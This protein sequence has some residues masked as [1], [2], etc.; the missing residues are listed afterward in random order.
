MLLSRYSINSKLVL[1]S[2]LPLLALLLVLIYDGMLLYDFQ[3]DSRQTQALIELTHKLDG[4]AHQHAVERGLTAGFLGSKGRKGKDKV[5]AQREKADKATEEWHNFLHT[6]EYAQDIQH[7]LTD[8]NQLLEQKEAV[9]NKVDA[10]SPDNG[11]FAYYSALNKKALDYVSQLATHIKNESLRNEVIDLNA[12]LWMKERAGQSRGLLNGIYAR[13]STNIESYANVYRYINEFDSRLQLLLS[14]ENLHSRDDLLQATETPVFTQVSSIEQRF[15]GQADSLNAI[16]GPTS[17]KWFPLA[18]ERIKVL[19][20]VI[21]EEA[22]FI[23]QQVN[24]Q[25]ANS[26]RY[27]FGGL[28]A[29]LVFVGLLAWLALHI[30]RNISSRIKGISQLLT[31]SIQNNDLSIQVKDIGSDEIAEIASGIDSY[32]EWLRD[33]IDDVKQTTKSAI[34]DTQVFVERAADNI[35][36]MEDQQQQTQL[37]ASAITEMS[38][39]I[40]EVSSSCQVVA[41]LSNDVQDNSQE[42]DK[43]SEKAADSV[44]KLSEKITASEQILSQLSS[45]SEDIGGILDSIRGI[46]EQTNLLALNAAIE[47]ARAGEQGR[48]FAVVADEVRNLAQRT[49]ESTEEIQTMISS[50]QD[51]AAKASSTMNESKSV[52]DVCLEDSNNVMEKSQKIYDLIHQVNDQIIQV[53]SI[54]EQQ[55][56]VSN[57]IAAN[58]ENINT[59]TEQA[60]SV[61][62]FIDKNSQSLAHKLNELGEHISVFKTH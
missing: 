23:T 48:G 60:V 45:N 14:H 11:A 29:M 56:S 49:Q 47:A 43:L 26:Q 20:G 9:R 41:S 25:L 1:L 8:L 18:T 59:H 28:I 32:I 62:T 5:I 54:A 50:L 46:A 16:D 7:T 44:G 58:A 24:Q 21:D 3:K 12:M 30:S 57:E 6:N 55:S 17:D 53:S 15:L 22:R 27:L 36:T 13:G 51:S 40:D 34:T 39:S 38:A 35:A 10:L 19:K 31:N 2:S 42:G 4:I 37:V 61:A 33:I 52:V